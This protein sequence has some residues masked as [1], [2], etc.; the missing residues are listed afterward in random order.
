[1]VNAIF[2]AHGKLA[3]AMLESVQMVYGDA[4][5]V[6]L[7]FV[8]GENASDIINK[9]EKLVSIHAHDEWL[10][11]VDLQCGSPW[12]AAAT[13]A[14]Q[15]PHLRVMSGLSLPLA[16]ELVD[17]QSSMNVDELCVH[18]TQVASQTCVIWQQPDTT[19]EEF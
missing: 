7:E 5:V 1:M 13:L 8:P 17:N 11:A 9:L 12:N 4:N 6:A 2:C 14:M 15:N 10:I 3:C 16:L 18:L 19:D